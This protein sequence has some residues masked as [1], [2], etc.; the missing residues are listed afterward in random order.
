MSNLAKEL[1]TEITNINNKIKEGIE[2]NDQEMFVM[3]LSSL[4]NEE[5]NE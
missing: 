4:L 2:L 3:V 5:S 1:E